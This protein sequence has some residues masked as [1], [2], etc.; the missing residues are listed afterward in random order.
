MSTTLK[1]AKKISPK[2][3]PKPK[4]VW[5]GLQSH[6]LNFSGVI[7]KSGSLQTKPSAI[8]KTLE[9]SIVGT[10]QPKVF[11]VVVE[12]N[13]EDNLAKPLPIEKLRKSITDD[14]IKVYNS[15]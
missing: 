14:A 2:A 12:K 7:N 6:S 15:F 13:V 3:A 5:Q 4:I 11:L 10:K 1:K 9:H 8:K